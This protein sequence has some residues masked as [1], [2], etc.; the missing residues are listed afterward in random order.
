MSFLSKLTERVVKNRLTN[1]IS[2]NNLLNS[3]QSA[4]TKYH[5]TETTLLAVHDH[6]IRA[7]SQQ[8][9]TCLCLVDLS[10]AFDTTDHS[11]LIERLSSWFGISGTALNWIK[12]YLSSRSFHVKIKNSQSSVFQ[13]FYGVPQ[14][15]VLGPLLFTLYTTPL[16]T[17]ISQYGANHHLYADDTQLFISFTSSEFLKNIAIL[18]NTIDKVCSWMSANLL[19]LNPS[20]TDFLLIGLPKQLSKL[21][22]PTTNV[23]F[24]VTFIYLLFLRLEI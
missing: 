22:N 19:M 24:D 1:F 13:L 3:S 4:Y 7:I 8:Q 14:G 15:S 21:N 9:I 17:V 2:N 18:E 20:K 12:S 5:S 11:I 10:A 23:T 6:I 16:S